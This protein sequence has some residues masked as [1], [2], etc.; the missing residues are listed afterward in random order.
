M[1]LTERIEFW[2]GGSDR[3]HDRFAYRVMM[4]GR[5]SVCG[6]IAVARVTKATRVVR[7]LGQGK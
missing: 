5:S 6:L 7:Q 1:W 3:L 4:A 2:Q